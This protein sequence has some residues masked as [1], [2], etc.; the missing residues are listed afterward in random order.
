MAIRIF[1]IRPVFW[2]T[3]I[4]AGAVA[5]ALGLGTWQ[6]QR[7]F[8]KQA[9]NE[10][11][12]AR[13]TAPP[14]EK[15]PEKFDPAQH[16]FR[17]VRLT[18]SFLNGHELFLAARSLRGNPGWHLITP[19]AVSGGPTIL[20]NRGWLPL[21]HKPP[22]TRPDSQI[23]GATKIVG[24]LRLP[25]GKNAFTPD[26]KPDEGGWFWVDLPAMAKRAGLKSH[27]A[28]YIELLQGG[29]PGTYPLA[30]QSRIQARNEHLQYVITWYS[31]AIA[32]FVIW[33]LWH[34]G[35]ARELAKRDD[36][37]A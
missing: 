3:F 33:L 24:I 9:I 6:V 25:P 11:R 4:T 31:L 2:P 20:V 15:L 12:L 35:R 7:L 21:S 28:Y 30:A 34:R 16:Q 14:L 23:P 5:L 26:N 19:F 29:T 17:R 32:G 18:G 10:S 37:Q 22:E 27:P 36:G 1:G 13:V 8:W